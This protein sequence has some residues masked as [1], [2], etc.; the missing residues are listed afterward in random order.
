VPAMNLIATPA[1]NTC[2]SPVGSR[3]I[4]PGAIVVGGATFLVID[5]Q[6]PVTLL[7]LVLPPLC[8]AM[9]FA[10]IYGLGKLRRLRKQLA[11][12]HGVWLLLLLSSL[13]FRIRDMHAIESQ[14]VDVWAV[15]RILLVA[16][17][18]LLL[19]FCTFKR[20]GWTCVLVRGLTG[21]L[22]AYVLVCIVSTLWSVYPAWTLYKSLEYFVDLAL[23]A[24]V[25]ATVR[26]VESYKTLFDWTWVLA[27][28]LLATVWAGALLWPDRAFPI[29]GELLR[30]RIAG[31]V[32]AQDPNNV[33][34]GAAILAIV[35]LTR[36]QRRAIRAQRLFYLVVFIVSLVTLIVSQTR[37]AIVGFLLGALLV[38]V[39]SRSYKALTVIALAIVLLV[40]FTSS[41]SIA[42]TF[43]QRGESQ[44]AVEGFSGRLPVWQFGWQSFV[45]QPLT[46]YGAY[47]AGRFSVITG[48]VDPD[49]SSTLS[50]YVEILVG[51]GACGLIPIV[52]ALVGSWWLLVRTC[53]SGNRQT[54]PYQL[55]VEAIGVL[56]II[57]TRSFFSVGMIWHPAQAFLL[58]AGY[59]EFL[60]RMSRYKSMPIAPRRLF[61]FQPPL[62]QIRNSDV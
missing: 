14:V 17:S 58:V 46:G 41:S 24:A 35:A 34:E 31:V 57:T 2:H 36:L 43:W 52:V 50:D 25:L 54:L 28:G 59:A 32:P 15:Y 8:F 42:K 55:A 1:R 30:V 60:R 51:T 56:A 53:R 11:W 27:T 38:L 62:I 45:N 22:A 4:W 5:L 29:N 61:A 12:W 10:A 47:A 48:I 23:I 49:W 19:L 21:A 3:L 39:F 44:D 26:S 6:R 13:V 33:G 16:I 20:S 40:S 7:F 37:S 9:F 18:V